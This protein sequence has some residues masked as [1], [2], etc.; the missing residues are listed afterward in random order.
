MTDVQVETAKIPG[1]EGSVRAGMTA[2]AAD[3][4]AYFRSLADRYGDYVKLRLIR[5]EGVL[6]VDPEAIEEVLV[7]KK[8]HFIKGRGTHSLSSLLGNGLLVSEGEFWRRQRRLAQPA[9]HKDRIAKYAERMVALGSQM[10]DRWQ[11]GQQ[12]DIH[13]E[14]TAATLS[15]VADA[16]F[17]ADVS[18]ARA[19]SA[20]DWRRCSAT[21]S[22]GRA[23]GSSSRSGCRSDPT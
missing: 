5:G 6:L 18:R 23:P 7:R 14:M 12:M 13:E 2:F 4:L 9:F 11:P 20:A 21:S 15:I 3:P 16:L 22:G 8:R 17:S 10:L 1:P 19:T